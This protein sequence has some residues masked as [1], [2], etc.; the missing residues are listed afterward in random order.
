MPQHD[1]QHGPSRPHPGSRQPV[2]SRPHVDRSHVHCSCPRHRVTRHPS[3]RAAPTA[4]RTPLSAPAAASPADPHLLR[5]AL[6]CTEGARRAAGAPGGMRGD[7]RFAMI[8]SSGVGGDGDCREGLPAD[9]GARARAG[10]D[11][12]PSPATSPRQRCPGGRSAA[13]AAPHGA[14]TSG[15]PR[16]GSAPAPEQRRRQAGMPT[17]TPP[18]R[19][20]ARGHSSPARFASASFSASKREVVADNC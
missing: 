2:S 14:A 16:L 17:R 15:L 3:R 10:P 8:G 4:D 11:R 7:G 1:K 6:P 18:A 12:R 5:H 13:A 20:S 19:T 9:R